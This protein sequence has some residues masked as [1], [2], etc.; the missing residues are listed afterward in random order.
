MHPNM[1]HYA[2]SFAFGL[3]IGFLLASF[4]FQALAKKL[5]D[6]MVE[7]FA[8]TIARREAQDFHEKITF[9]DE[10]TQAEWQAFA[11]K[12]GALRNK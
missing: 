10:K 4:Y 3:S 8:T 11:K 6:I 7:S 5:C 1:W 9:E 12:L 2:I